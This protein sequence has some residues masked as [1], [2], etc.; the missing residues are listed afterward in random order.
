M[1]IYL[2]E[3]LEQSQKSH[4]QEPVS[5]LLTPLSIIHFLFLLVF[6]GM[7]FTLTF[8]T[9]DRFGFS[10]LDQGKLLGFMGILTALIQGGYVRRKSGGE[11]ELVLQ[12]IWACALGLGVIGVLAIDSV[13]YLYGGVMLLSITTGTV[14]TSLTA[15]AAS[16]GKSRSGEVLGGFRAVGQ[17]GRCLGPLV[18]C[19]CY[20]VFGSVKAYTGYAVAMACV[21]VLAGLILPK[22]EKMKKE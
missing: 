8:L 12:G 9:F 2:P 19:S 13:L 18:A 5:K 3:T 21:G 7:E 16:K 6:S 11:R 17:L 10:N 1:Y 20:W 14:S 22:V 15:I 4:E